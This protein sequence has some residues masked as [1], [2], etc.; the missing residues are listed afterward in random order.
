MREVSYSVKANFLYSI[1][2]KNTPKTVN[3]INKTIVNN[4]YLRTIVVTNNNSNV[5]N[6]CL[7]V[8]IV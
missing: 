3:Y 5:I 2:H 6:R 4:V 7:C 8:T 1:I